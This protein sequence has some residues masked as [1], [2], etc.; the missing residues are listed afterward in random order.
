MVAEIPFQ[1]QAGP[2]PAGLAVSRI[3]P[4]YEQVGDQLRD[5]IVSGQLQPGDRLPVEGKLA[6]TFGVSRST[7]REAL[8]SLAAHDLVYTRR[9]VNGGTFIADTSPVLLS[10]SL[11]AGLHI[12]SVNQAITTVEL[13]EARELFEVPATRLAAKRRTPSQI[14][15]MRAAIEAENRDGDRSGTFNHNTLFHAIVLQAAGN[16]LAE[17]LI[18]PVYGVIRSRFLTDEADRRF[19]TQVDRDHLLILR[20]IEAG[21]EDAAAASMQ[22]HLRRLNKAYRQRDPIG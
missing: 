2:D 18:A 12:L 17:L 3:K 4:A 21:D 19:W 8:R 11:E 9:G 16:R 22:A 5:L 15:D 1:A 10:S 14:A 7:V 20:D 13:L 6:L